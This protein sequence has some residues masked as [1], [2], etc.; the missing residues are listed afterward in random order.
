MRRAFIS[1]FDG[2][3]GTAVITS[4][5]NL[6]WTDGRYWLQA[7]KQLS[8]DWVTMKDRLAETPTVEDWLC[9]TL[10][11]GDSVGIDPWLVSTAVADKYKNT[12]D[13]HGIHLVSLHQNP[14]DTVWDA[15]GRK[16]PLKH[17]A[18]V[19]PVSLAG[20]GTSEKLTGIREKLAKE[21]ATALI[22]S[23]LDEVAWLF[24]V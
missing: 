18:L 20:V 1:G 14:V 6:L 9:T 8:E 17:P 11:K 16:Q 21:G 23:A 5:E 4:K 12:F 15:M 19:Q 7:S 22:V 24:N 13:K 10:S 3:A 2:S